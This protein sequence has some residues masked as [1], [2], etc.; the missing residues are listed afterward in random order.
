MGN[1]QQTEK[2]AEL[3]KQT[4]EAHHE[5]FAATDGEDADLAIWYANDLHASGGPG[6]SWPRP[7]RE[8]SSPGAPWY[9]ALGLRVLRRC[10]R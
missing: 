1:E 6:R 3:L 10:P 9:R 5:A 4:G 2:L 7:R 8:T